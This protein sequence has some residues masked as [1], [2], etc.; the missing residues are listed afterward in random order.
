MTEKIEHQ[1]VKTHD[2]RRF[3]AEIEQ[4][5]PLT[6][7][8]QLRVRDTIEAHPDCLAV[9]WDDVII[10]RTS[11]FRINPFR[12]K[13]PKPDALF[14]S[15]ADL[16]GHC[17][18]DTATMRRLHK[19]N[20]ISTPED[21]SGAFRILAEEMPERILFAP[22]V[23]RYTRHAESEI[24][25]SVNAA[26]RP[27]RRCESM[28]IIVN[29]RDRP[30]LM[31]HCLQGI[32][33]QKTTA[34]VEI[35]LVNNQSTPENLAEIHSQA[36]RIIKPPMTVLHLD[37]DYPFNKS[38][39][40]NLAAETSKG[41]V[42]VFFNNDA[43]LLSENCLQ[44][45]SD[46]ALEPDVCCTG[47]RILGDRDRLVS[48]GV[49]AR[50][51]MGEMPSLIR[52]NE[53]EVFQDCIR[54]TVGISFACSAVSRASYNAVGKLDEIDFKSQYNDADFFI[55]ALHE[56]MYHLQIGEVS[57]RHEPGASEARTKEK[58]MALLSTFRQRYPEL[59]SYADI[60]FDA[61]KMRTIP[62][63]PEANSAVNRRMHFIRWWRK[64]Q[65]QIQ[66]FRDASS[67]MLRLNK[68]RA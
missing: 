45:I 17:A 46:W 42:I 10:R 33:S 19:Q 54:P 5:W 64:V 66:R 29:Y 55:R 37:Y 28:S 43:E 62:K 6:V 40:D 9:Y 65:P 21:V 34:A 13:W 16:T 12:V 8:W 63:F 36:E 32:A 7:K 38:A 49:F 1:Q 68:R 26:R 53:L 4:N 59:G 47:P 27:S 35:V 18:V 11:G 14:L 41:E 25:K 22:D 48:N 31:E 2:G 56:G 51:A 60:D 67:R 15:Q 44:T 58:T 24:Y 3:L 23:L 39:Q 52:E 57:C 50:S 61:L 20:R 30:D